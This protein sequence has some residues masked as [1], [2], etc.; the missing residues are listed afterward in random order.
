MSDPIEYSRALLAAE[1]LRATPLA[2]GLGGHGLQ[3]R[4]GRLINPRPNRRRGSALLAALIAVL[5]ICLATPIHNSLGQS[6]TSPTGSENK[7][8][9]RFVRVVVGDNSVMFEG[10]PTTLDLLPQLLESLA[11]RGDTVLQLAYASNDVKMGWYAQVESQILND[12]ER[13]KL[14]FK[15]FSEV[16]LQP[17]GAQGLRAPDP[18]ALPALP[19]A[20]VSQLTQ[21]VPFKIGYSD[22]AGGDRIT[23]TEVHGT[24]DAIS[25]G[26]TYQVKGTYHLASHDQATLAMSVTATRPQDA[27]GFWASNQSIN[28]QRGDGEFTVYE[29]I[30]CPGYPH[31]TIY[32]DGKSV[33]DVYFGTGDSLLK[34]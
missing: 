14:G 16:G 20:P 3:S 13:S 29:C 10:K 33:S 24:S 9:V 28:I 1:G 5:L 21:I 32:A 22:L 12:T 26:N 7:N 27:R 2:M 17:I 31:I 6:T 30:P 23:I 18:A 11:D 4:I 15:Y 19:Q 25:P 34:K 8:G